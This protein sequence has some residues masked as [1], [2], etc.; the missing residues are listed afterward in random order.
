MNQETPHLTLAPL[1]QRPSEA[2]P[3]MRYS[4]ANRA[5]SAEIDYHEPEQL[6]SITICADQRRTVHGLYPSLASA[7]L[8]LCA[9]G[10]RR[11]ELAA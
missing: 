11:E 9:L 8:I 3:L 6:W 2:P 10:F 7:Q 1:L 4:H 5:R